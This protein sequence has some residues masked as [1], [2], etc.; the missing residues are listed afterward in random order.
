M[1]TVHSTTQNV[2][3]VLFR[4]QQRII[5]NKLVVTAVPAADFNAWG[6]E[7]FNEAA[8]RTTAVRGSPKSTSGKM[9][10]GGCCLSEPQSLVPFPT[11]PSAGSVLTCAA[12]GVFV[13]SAVLARHYRH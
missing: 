3:G 10:R 6:E 1:I 11:R 7:M 5:L 9:E 4:M 13:I 12:T 8:L 2:D